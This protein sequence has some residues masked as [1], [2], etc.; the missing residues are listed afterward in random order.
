MKNMLGYVNLHFRKVN[1]LM[2]LLFILCVIG[3]KLLGINDIPENSLLENAQLIALFAGFVLCLKFKNNKVLFNFAA[4][5]VFLMI[6]RELSYGRCIFCQLPDNPHDFYPWSHYKYGFLA[7][8]FVGI[9][10]AASCLYAIVK[11]VWID[12]KDVVTKAKFPVWDFLILGS[13]T[14]VQL[15]AESGIHNTCLEEIA[16]FMMYSVIFFFVYYYYRKIGM[17]S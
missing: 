8:V 9:Y 7:H 2:I 10:I 5:I 17:I 1:A 15:Y 6:M 16:E 11:K 4:M 13:F 3:A 14:L 12:V